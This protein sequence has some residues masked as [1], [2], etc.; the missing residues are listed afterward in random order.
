MAM[1]AVMSAAARRWRR[2]VEGSM[3][4]TILCS[5]YRGHRYVLRV[6]PD[7]QAADGW[8]GGYAAIEPDGGVRAWTAVLHLAAL[9]RRRPR[10]AAEALQAVKLAIITRHE[11]LTRFV[12]GHD[13]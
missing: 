12:P 3:T 11:A 1:L 9:L 7:P 10:S 2:A 8:G 13:E 4:E 6:Y 5:T